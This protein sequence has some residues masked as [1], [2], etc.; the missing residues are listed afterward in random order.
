[1][2]DDVLALLELHLGRGKLFFFFF[3]LQDLVDG[4]GHGGDFCRPRVCVG[5]VDGSGDDFGALGFAGFDDGFDDF[6]VGLRG[7]GAG[8]AGA[9]GA[10]GSADAVE[11]YFVGLGGFVVDDGGDVLDVET[12][13]GD[14]GGEE[15][16]NGGRAKGFD[17]GNTL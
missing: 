4:V 16:G 8:S 9:A 11:V 1:M 10:G 12:A 6:A 14:I 7:D 17:G 2:V 15:E 5:D 3:V 13:R